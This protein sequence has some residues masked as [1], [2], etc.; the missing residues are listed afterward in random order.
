[1]RWL[2]PG[3]LLWFA[4]AP[5]AGARSAYCRAVVKHGRFD[6]ETRRALA[7]WEKLLGE[8]TN[9]RILGNAALMGAAASTIT[10]VV[11]VLA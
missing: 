1:M 7:E 2:I 3:Y 5:L 4:F 9:R 6:G 8:A 11:L 10:T